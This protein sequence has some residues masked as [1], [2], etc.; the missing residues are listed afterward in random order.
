MAKP[1]LGTYLAYLVE[2]W[3]FKTN[4]RELRNCEGIGTYN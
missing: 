1:E 4:C 2:I 3:Q